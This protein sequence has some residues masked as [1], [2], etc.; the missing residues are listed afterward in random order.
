MKRRPTLKINRSRRLLLHTIFSIWCSSFIFGQEATSP[1]AFSFLKKSENSYQKAQIDSSRIYAQLAYD[2]CLQ[3]KDTSCMAQSLQLIAKSWELDGEIEKALRNYLLTLN[4]RERVKQEEKVN[5]L[6]FEL[7]ELYERWH[8][9]EKAFR[10]HSDVLMSKEASDNISLRLKTLEGM[11]QN[12]YDLQQLEESQK[13]NFD[14]YAIHDSLNNEEGRIES[15]RQI[16]KVFKESQQFEKAL[17]YNKQLLDINIAQ[18][19]TSEIIISLNNIGVLYRQL[20]NLPEALNYFSLAFETEEQFRP[21]EGGNPITLT[22]VGILYQNL[23]DYSNSLSN[24][25]KAESKLRKMPSP[26]FRMLANVSNLIAIIYLNTNDINNAYVYNQQAISMAL[27][28]KDKN[29]EQLCYRTRASIFEQINDFK[30]A[31]TFYQKHALLKDTLFQQRLSDQE[32]QL[33]RRFSVEQT[34]KEMS[35]LLIDREIEALKF[36]QDSLENERLRQEKALQASQLEREQLEREQAQQ[37][38]EL[39]Q[40]QYEAENTAQALLLAKRQLETEQKDRQIA[41][42]E[43]D[44]SEQALELAQERLNLEVKDREI[45]LAAKDQAQLD[46]DLQQKNFELKSQRQR[47]FRS[48]MLGFMLLFLIISG[49]IYRLSRLRRKANTILSTQKQELEQ[50]LSDLKKAQ[51]QLVQSEKMASLGQLTAGIAHEINNPLNF[52]ST[53]AR[54]L[55]MDL[56]EINLLLDEV[57][58]LQDNSSKEQV[59]KILEKIK[60]LDTE[61]IRNEMNELIAGIERGTIRTQHIVSGLR[62]FSRNTDGP[63]RGANIHEGLESTLIILN[64]RLKG[65]IKVHKDYGQLPLVNCQLD[66]LNQ[67]FMNIISNAIE[68]IPENGDLYIKTRQIEKGVEIKIRDNGVGMPKDIQKRIF[69]PF[70]TTKEVGKGTGLGLSISYGII[71]QHNGCISVNSEAGQGTEFIINLPVI[72]GD[73]VCKD[74]KIIEPKH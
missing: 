61:F 2:L 10:H 9:Y 47:L 30:E 40:Q 41:L 74:D 64:S 18:K 53:N 50:L 37:A 66:K 31:F 14:I 6:H 39:A 46:L 22:N 71:E 42:L 29:I 11:A 60:V 44:Q 49:F 26:D 1:E 7:A 8:I 12:K 48:L 54:A 35:L 67:V 72:M 23:G 45:A 62:I 58:S 20:K 65:R 33:M 4:L 28:I 13:Y 51:T 57:H 3:Q 59:S 5:A 21:K 36:R 19:D 17:D 68:A 73:T 52:V 43:K 38:L 16:I 55:K 24:L 69:E 34:E 70:Y 27:T 25:L 32:K 56:E 63:F 15:L